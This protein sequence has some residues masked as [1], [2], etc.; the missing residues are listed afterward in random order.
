MNLEKKRF[1]N[2]NIK[3]HKTIVIIV[4]LIIALGLSMI[5]ANISKSLAKEKTV[6]VL[7]A[8]TKIRENTEIS[9]KM[10]EVAYIRPIKGQ[11]YVSTEELGRYKTSSDIL[12]GEAITKGRLND[13]NSKGE[14]KKIAYS[15][16]LDPSDAVAGTLRAGDKVN[17]IS[18][19]ASNGSGIS[20]YLFEKEKNVPK[21]IR[22][23]SV[24]DANSMLITDNSIPGSVIVLELDEEEA[25]SLRVAEL[26][27]NVKLVLAK[28]Q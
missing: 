7:I 27:K 9:D 20:E 23:K 19:V 6:P 17:V 13:I 26:A 2:L 11:E 8:T 14:D 12:E 4:S 24:Y 15:L 1:K 22:V 3:K 5:S 18:A 28:N 16:R 25:T 10:Y 21:A